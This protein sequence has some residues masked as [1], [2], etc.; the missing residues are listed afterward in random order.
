[1]VS[2]SALDEPMRCVHC[3]YAAHPRLADEWVTVKSTCPECGRDPVTGKRRR[4]SKTP[5]AKKRTRRRRPAAPT[6]GGQWRK[7]KDVGACNGCGAPGF[8]MPSGRSKDPEF[9][10]FV[11]NIAGAVPRLCVTCLQTTA[12]VI[13]LGKRERVLGTKNS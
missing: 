9:E 2:V 12:E 8:H 7:T 11:L 3:N 13:A 10:V 1:M 6:I 4:K 5:P